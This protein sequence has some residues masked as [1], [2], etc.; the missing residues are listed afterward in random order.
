MSAARRQRLRGETWYLLA[1]PVGGRSVRL[2]ATAYAIAGRLDGQRSV[3]QLWDRQMAQHADPV[4]PGFLLTAF[5]GVI[6]TW[7]NHLQRLA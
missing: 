7:P 4:T 2:N 6:C 1:D 5:R 3:Q